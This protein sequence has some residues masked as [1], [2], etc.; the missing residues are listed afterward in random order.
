MDKCLNCPNAADLAP[1]A[2][3]FPRS[4]EKRTY[5]KVSPQAAWNIMEKARSSRVCLRQA[6]LVSSGGKEVASNEC[7]DKRWIHK[8]LV[9]YYDRVKSVFV[10]GA[11]VQGS[12]ILSSEHC[13]C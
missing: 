4:G 10:S 5:S 9:M 8:R 3:T 12:A 13:K 11:G 7:E 2:L 6:L 1:P